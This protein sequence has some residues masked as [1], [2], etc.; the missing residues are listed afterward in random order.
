M[1][2]YSAATGHWHISKPWDCGVYCFPTNPY[3]LRIL[4]DFGSNIQIQG[5][6]PW[7]FLKN[8]KAWMLKKKKSYGLAKFWCWNYSSL[9]HPQFRLPQC[10]WLYGD[11]ISRRTDDSKSWQGPQGCGELYYI[12]LLKLFTSQG[13]HHHHHHHQIMWVCLKIGVQLTPKFHG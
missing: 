12:V 11:P 2:F 1:G 7:S 13:H 8:M 4:W 6:I 5:T 3:H 9:S 10:F